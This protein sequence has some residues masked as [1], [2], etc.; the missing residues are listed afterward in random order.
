MTQTQTITEQGRRR[1]SW[2]KRLAVFAGVPLLAGAA[3]TG[4]L[5]LYFSAGLP[6]HEQLVDYRPALGTQVLSGDGQF[7]TEFARER[8]TFVPYSEIPPRLVQAFLAAEDKTFFTHSGL[9]YPG[10]AQA[11]LTNWK[12]RGS[13]RRPIGAS[14]ITQQ[15]AKI[16]IQ[17]SS[18][19][20]V[21]KVREAILATRL[22][23]AFTKERILEL[24]LSQIFLGRNSYGVA[25]AALAYFDKSLDQLTLPEMAFL[26]ALPK[27]PSNYNPVTHPDRARQRRDFVLE[28][29]AAN[30]FI[31]ARQLEEARTWPVIAVVD[32]P[33]PSTTFRADYFLE[34]VRR[35]VKQRYGDKG[36]YEDGLTVRTTLD[37]RLQAM[38]EKAFRDGLVRYDR[39]RGWRG[40]YSSVDMSGDWR[41]ALRQ[42]DVPV[43]YLD[44]KAAVVTGKNG[45]RLTIGFADGVDAVVPE[46]AT[47]WALGAYNRLKP[48]D[49]VPV[50]PIGGAKG[51]YKLEQIP[52]VSGGFVALDPAT[53]RVLA[54]VG[55]FDAR[56]SEFNRAT[57]ARRQPG[58]A[59]KPFVYAAALDNGYTPSSIIVDG[60]FCIDQGNGLGEWCP[61]NFSRRFYGPS[62]L[63]LGL[64]LSRNLM[65][66]RLADKIGMTKVSA[67]AREMGINDKLMPVLAM[68]LGAGETTLLRLVNAYGM[69]ANNGRKLTPTLIDRIQDRDGKT[70]WRHDNRACIGCNAEDWGG[71]GMPRIEDD[72]PQAIDPRTAYQITHMLEGVIERGTATSLRVLNRPLA[73][74][75]GTT[76]DATNVWFV[77]MSPNIVAGVY[78]GYD[79]LRSLGRNVQG[80]TDAAPIVRDFFIP[81]LKDMP[82]TPF[83]I[84]EGV[85]LVRIDLRSGR[86]A[87]GNGAGVIWEAYKP[88]TEPLR[89]SVRQTDNELFSS[90]LAD[91]VEDTGGIY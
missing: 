78:I 56:K 7:L 40:P 55:G 91:F 72:R 25:A 58:S 66:V 32:M 45:A 30:G 77:G 60:K 39:R 75:T 27:A 19:S 90:P 86:L 12:L 61:E 49:V 8:R 83:A 46:Y 37:T 65:T 41:R 14:T 34:E 15:L 62:T 6:D 44:W 53:G 70:I 38:A 52:E 17:D 28:Q 82:V 74:K 48:G 20:V 80:G 31:S 76:N 73:G 57:Q 85:R 10:I 68:S 79:K 63:R 16:L 64:E 13:G 54:M 29:M 42:L 3:L 51:Q 35:D 11:M 33:A 24:Y 69:L 50:S 43:G 22:E 47:R 21:R 88:G 18:V 4:G 5:W 2:R 26:A 89:A 59:F 9:D 67:V 84:P 87:G 81:A 71:E 36:L 23:R 1:W